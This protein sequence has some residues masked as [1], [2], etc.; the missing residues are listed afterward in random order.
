MVVALPHLL[1]FHDY[2][3]QLCLS[4]DSLLVSSLATRVPPI[5]T[6]QWGRWTSRAADISQRLIS[7]ILPSVVY[8][9]SQ[10]WYWPGEVCQCCCVGPF[11]WCGEV[12]CRVAWTRFRNQSNARLPLPGNP[13]SLSVLRSVDRGDCCLL[14]LSSPDDYCCSTQ[15]W[16]SSFKDHCECPLSQYW[17]L[18]L[19]FLWLLSSGSWYL[20]LEWTRCWRKISCN[21][22][23]WS[24][25]YCWICWPWCYLCSS[26]WQSDPMLYSRMPAINLHLLSVTKD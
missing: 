17:T 26:W 23:T 15:S 13:T 22:R 2:F 10:P 1:F 24:R 20:Y 4:V 9:T 21:F 5:W 3:D 19:S 25:S 16:W 8:T 18:P 12:I 14:I 7:A 11:L 6:H